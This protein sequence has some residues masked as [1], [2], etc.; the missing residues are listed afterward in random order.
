MDTY[1]KLG[2]RH[3]ISPGVLRRTPE[4][5]LASVKLVLAPLHLEVTNLSLSPFLS[6]Q[7]PRDIWLCQ[8][9]GSRR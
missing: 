8:A 2:T 7:H 3:H 5:L 6:V 9:L 4:Y 1:V